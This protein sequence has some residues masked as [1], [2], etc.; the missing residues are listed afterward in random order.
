MNNY[1]SG[2]WLIDTASG[3]PIVQPNARVTIRSMKWVSLS[4]VT[5]DL[6]II[7]DGAGNPVWKGICSGPDF[8]TGLFSLGGTRTIRGLTVPTLASGEIYLYTDAI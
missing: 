3:T 2:I 4:G 1:S 8:D 7:Q 6:A 5:G